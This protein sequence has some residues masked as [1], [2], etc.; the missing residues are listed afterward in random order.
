[1]H[2]Y[3]ADPVILMDAAIKLILPVK[4]A[5]RLFIKSLTVG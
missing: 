5:F 1:M 4:S 2:R 3:P